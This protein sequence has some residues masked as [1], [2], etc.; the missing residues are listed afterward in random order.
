MSFC[1]NCGNPTQPNARFCECCGA[2]ISV[3]QA[4]NPVHAEDADGL[5]LAKADNLFADPE[6]FSGDSVSS[7][8]E[9]AANPA[10]GSTPETAGITPG[11]GGGPIWLN[12]K[13]EPQETVKPFFATGPDAAYHAPEESIPMAAAPVPNV[14]IWL[15]RKSDLPEDLDGLSLDDIDPQTT[16]P[17]DEV[18]WHAK[19]GGPIPP[20]K[21]LA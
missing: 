3:P 19:R 16:N 5:L 15:S 18:S 11:T 9:T 13:P 4:A 12:A 14:P 20:P 6:D 2:K 7:Q 21:G 10:A 8:N 17:I 1:S